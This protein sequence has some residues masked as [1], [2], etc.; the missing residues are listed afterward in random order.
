VLL[1]AFAHARGEGA[2]VRLAIVGDGQLRPE[3]E[4]LAAEL[5][6][7]EQVWFAGYRASMLPVTAA[8]DVAVLSSDNEGTPVSLIE[9]AAAGTPSVAT[10]VGG[11]PHVV[12]P[13]TGALAPTGDHYAL[14]GAIAQLASDPALRF[15]RGER[16]RAHVASRFG[17]E[18]LV[19]DVE[20]LYESLL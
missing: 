8:S 3:L 14:G 11:V 4:R 5:G 17:V 6:V 12:T 13:D 9:A 18:R 7:R 10:A 15:E 1:R 20:S 2:P 19:R 16:A